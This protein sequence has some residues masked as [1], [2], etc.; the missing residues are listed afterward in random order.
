[1]GVLQAGGTLGH[2]NFL[3]LLSHF[4][5][6][7]GIA[8]LL[9]GQRGW[10][11]IVGPVSGLVAAA[12]TVS[13]ATV[14]LLAAGFIAL[15]CLSA[16]RG[17][18][19]RKAHVLVVSIALAVLLMP[20]VVSSFQ[21]RFSFS[22]KTIGNN[23]DERAAFEKAATMMISDHPLGVGANSYVLI[24]NTEGYN[25]RAGVAW[26]VGSESTNVHNVYYLVAAETGYVGL[27]TFLLVL[28]VPLVTAFRC[29]R[30]Y[31]H[32][33]R[34]DFLLGMGMSLLIVYIHS[35]FEWV[36]ITFQGQYMFALSAGMIAGTAKQLG[37]WRYPV[38][39]TSLAV[40]SH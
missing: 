4:V 21:E 39:K 33:P 1:L 15:F 35:Y 20:L 13:R 12:L 7:P 34:G 27:L 2:E 16:R 3:G 31:R 24:A 29:A 9:A 37:Y 28:L 14:G 22:D 10:R 17:W 40:A 36:F 30:R 6:F 19:P 18:T 32:D 5:T 38:L 25:S 8:L 11:P 23:Y 26:V